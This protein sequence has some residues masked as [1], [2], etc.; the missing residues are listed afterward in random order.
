[1]KLD[2]ISM[3][4]TSKICS[5]FYNTPRASFCYPLFNYEIAVSFISL[6]FSKNFPCI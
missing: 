1:M 2:C 4:T 3:N 5:A 6:I